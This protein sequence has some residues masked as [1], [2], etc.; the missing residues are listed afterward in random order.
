MSHADGTTP[1]PFVPIPD[2]KKA[3]HEV[4]LSPTTAVVVLYS[5]LEYEKLSKLDMLSWTQDIGSFLSAKISYE[6]FL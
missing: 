3:F 2:K 5:P 6:R 4:E 1:C